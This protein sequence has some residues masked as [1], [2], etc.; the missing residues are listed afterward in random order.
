MGNR[1]LTYLDAMEDLFGEF[2]ALAKGCDPRDD[3]A[4]GQCCLPDAGPT[5]VF[6]RCCVD[7]VEQYCQSCPPGKTNAA[8]AGKA[9]DSCLCAEGL[10]DEFRSR[11]SEVGGV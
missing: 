7:Y 4:F 11:M 6:A 2:G 10:L 8:G 1:Y 5:K 9:L 3:D